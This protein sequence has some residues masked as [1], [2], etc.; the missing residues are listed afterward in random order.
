MLI[1]DAIIELDQEH[2]DVLVSKKVLKTESNYIMIDFLD[3]QMDDIRLMQKQASNAGKKSAES[4][5]AKRNGS[6]TTVQQ[7]FNGAPTESNREEKIRED[8]R[9][10]EKMKEYSNLIVEITSYLNQKTGKT[11][12]PST[13]ATKKHISARLNEGFKIDDFKK[14]VDVKCAKWRTDPKMKDFLRPETLFG[15]KFESY[16]NEWAPPTQQD[17]MKKTGNDVQSNNQETQY[18]AWK[19]NS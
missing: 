16:L 12:K 19:R 18:E 7:P 3:E 2:F 13:T 14:V 6:S 17:W 4:R 11:F 8:K 5:K 9:R 15:A 10:E 1:D